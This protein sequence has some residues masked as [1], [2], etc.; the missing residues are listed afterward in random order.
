MNYIIIMWT[1]FPWLNIYMTL[2]LAAG[3]AHP[4]YPGKQ[5][6]TF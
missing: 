3:T 6:F 5:K 1:P 4:D 2:G